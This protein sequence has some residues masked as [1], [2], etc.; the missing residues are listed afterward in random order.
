M[1]SGRTRFVVGASRG[2]RV[3][4]SI[5][6]SSTPTS[7]PAAAM[8]ATTVFSSGRLNLTGLPQL[9]RGIYLLGLDKDAW[10]TD[11]PLPEIDDTKWA[12]LAS[13]VVSVDKA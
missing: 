10:N 12:D 1:A 11:V 7:T 4:F 9:R 8:T 6:T 2:L 5:T 13:I 3:G